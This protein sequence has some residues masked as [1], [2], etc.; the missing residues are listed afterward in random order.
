MRSA[1]FAACIAATFIACTSDELDSPA[2]TPATLP[3]PSQTSVDVPASPFP[4]AQVV[5]GLD[6]ALVVRVIDGDTV[7]LEGGERLRYIGMDTPE[8]TTQHECFGEEATARNRD[9][10]EGHVVALETDVSDRDRFGRLLRYVYVDGVMVN[11][12]LVLEGYANASSFPPDVKYQERFLAAE[13]AAREAIAGLWSACIELPVASPGDCDLA[14]PDVCIPPP[15]PDLQCADV[16]FR[17][18]RV[19]PPDPH[20]FDG[21]NDGEGCEGP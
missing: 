8:S 19:L 13:A 1:V 12:L 15:P 5:S 21:N 14:Y 11:E 6:E 2:P 4:T 9:L 20:R 3:S 7:E 16:S 17:N 10:V 18:F